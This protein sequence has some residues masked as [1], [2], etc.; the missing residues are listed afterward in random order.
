MQ[1]NNVL[2][3]TLTPKCHHTLCRNGKETSPAP[4]QLHSGWAL[5][6]SPGEVSASLAREG[7]VSPRLSWTSSFENRRP[8]R[9]DLD[10]NLDT[11]LRV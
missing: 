6:Q 5:T 9:L 7:V 2:L 11:I 10:L 8:K 1:A 3:T 4:M